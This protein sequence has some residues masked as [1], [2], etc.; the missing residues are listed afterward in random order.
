MKTVIKLV[1]F[2][3]IDGKLTVFFPENILPAV[4]LTGSKPLDELAGDIFKLHLR[5]PL[6]DNYLEQLYTYSTSKRHNT[7]VTVVYYVLLP[8]YQIPLKD[9][10]NWYPTSKLTKTVADYKVIHYALQRLR[11][12]IEYTNI[13]YSL[14]PD[15]FTLSEL[16]T[17]YEAI[18]DRSLDKRNFRKKMLSLNILKS[19][20][21]IKKLGRAR[22]AEIFS[23]KR[24]K[25]TFV[26]IL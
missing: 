19:T 18:L 11:W 24:R 10:K 5:I 15:E 6:G 14:L 8:Q 22:P 20:G 21:K 26:E 16:Q 3:V 9:K 4:E 17:T 12:K 2:S 25:L 23:F 7:D 13:V 1:V